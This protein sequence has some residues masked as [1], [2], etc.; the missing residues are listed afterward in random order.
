MNVFGA[1][2]RI[3]YNP[4]T[5]MAVLVAVKIILL[6]AGLAVAGMAV[7][8]RRLLKA[9]AAVGIGALVLYG[10]VIGV[11][12]YVGGPSCAWRLA[13]ALMAAAAAGAAAG[14]A[15]GRHAGFAAFV[16]ALAAAYLAMPL[17]ALLA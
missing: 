15:S 6:A 11:W 7:G 17:A 14:F 2:G 12:L 1:H 8:Y 13:G 16:L 10:F 5:S 9:L 3:F 4:S